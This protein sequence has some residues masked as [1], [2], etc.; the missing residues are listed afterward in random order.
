MY[1]HPSN[2]ISPPRTKRENGVGVHHDITDLRYTRTVV[3]HTTSPHQRPLSTNAAA[4]DQSRQSKQQH[5]EN[6]EQSYT[7]QYQKVFPRYRRWCSFDV[8][9]K[10]SPR[11]DSLR[12]KRRE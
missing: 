7:V 8:T 10:L 9:S 5:T 3:Y 12:G 2:D 6:R 1:M 11:L 4:K